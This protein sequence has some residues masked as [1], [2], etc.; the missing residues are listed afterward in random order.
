M[1]MLGL[2]CDKGAGLGWAEDYCAAY[3]CRG[4][5]GQAACSPALCAAC[6]IELPV[7]AVAGWLHVS[8]GLKPRQRNLHRTERTT[9]VLR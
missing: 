1:H 6:V 8:H 5:H 9:G 2:N 7:L 4:L 3:D